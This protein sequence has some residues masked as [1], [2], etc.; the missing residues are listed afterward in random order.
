MNQWIDRFCRFSMCSAR[1]ISI[2]N[3]DAGNAKTE[4]G[5]W[6]QHGT[7]NL[8][9][10]NLRRRYQYCTVY[11]SRRTNDR[12]SHLRHKSL[13]SMGAGN[14]EYS[15]IRDFIFGAQIETNDRAVI[16]E[17][18]EVRNFQWPRTDIAEYDPF[19]RANPACTGRDNTDD[20]IS[21]YDD[22]ALVGQH[23]LPLG[24]EE[25]SAIRR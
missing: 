2:P 8:I 22:T 24:E 6:F 23:R 11:R 16:G 3:L 19:L 9:R 12:S 25:F 13:G 15:G 14:H 18:F 17:H 10:D 7:D 1:D 5:C 21:P 4:L 20:L